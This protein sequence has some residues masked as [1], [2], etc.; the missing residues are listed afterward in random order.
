MLISGEMFLV[1]KIRR[2][3]LFNQGLHDYRHNGFMAGRP[4]VVC[5]RFCAFL[6]HEDYDGYF[7]LG[8]KAL[9]CTER[10]NMFV[11]KSEMSPP[12]SV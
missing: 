3:M 5:V 7:S 12:T 1:H 10:S 8:E 11:S 9:R 4:A 6:M 2:G